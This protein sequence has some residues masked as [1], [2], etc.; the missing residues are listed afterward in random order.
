MLNLLS[1]VS[2]AIILVLALKPSLFRSFSMLHCH[3]APCCQ[4]PRYYS[5]CTI[6]ALTI[7]NVRARG[8]AAQTRFVHGQIRKLIWLR[9]QTVCACVKWP[10]RRHAHLLQAYSDRP[11]ELCPGVTS[12]GSFDPNMHDDD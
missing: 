12:P 10:A 6:S 5:K 8:D 4:Q 2:F 7:L 3:A 9:S 11:Q 1:Q